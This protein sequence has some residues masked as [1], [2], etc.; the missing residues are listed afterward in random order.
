MKLDFFFKMELLTVETTE[1]SRKIRRDAS[2]R[3]SSINVNLTPVTGFV[4]SVFDG[5]SVLTSRSVEGA[6][7]VSMAVCSDDDDSECEGPAT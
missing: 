7:E 2:V 6:C 5:L 3:L 1:L 4:L